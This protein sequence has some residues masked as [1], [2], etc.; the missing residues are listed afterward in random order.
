M[1]TRVTRNRIYDQKKDHIDPERPLKGIALNNYTPTTCL[2]ICVK[3]RE[4]IYYS[5]TSRGLFPEEQKG[6]RKRSRGSWELL[7]IDQHI[8]NEN[9]TRQKKSSYGLDG[10]QKG[11]WYGSAKL[12]NKLPQ[13][14]QNIRWSHKLYGENH[15][16]ME[17]GIDSWRKNLSGSEDPKRYISRRCAITVTTYNCDDLVSY[18]ARAEGLG[19]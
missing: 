17:S 10:L 16:N 15:E 9:K 13:N 18:P 1:P 2:P 19:K 3:T 8:L 6:W 7:Y 12:D 14:V 5:F 11:I 4:E